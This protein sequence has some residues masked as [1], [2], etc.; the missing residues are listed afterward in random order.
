MSE[1]HAPASL[2]EL[3]PEILE[4]ILSYLPHQHLTSFGRTS[5]RANEFIRPN[6]QI[7][8][9][10]CYLHI[11]DHPKHVWDSLV[12][13]ARA[14]NRH[15][16]ATWDWHHELRRRLVAA[17]A[18]CKPNKER[19]LTD[20]QDVVDALLDIRDTA[21]YS[22]TTESDEPRSMNLRFLNKLLARAPNVDPIVHDYHRDIDSMSLPLDLMA[23]LDRPFTRSML[24][25][26][27]QVPEWASRLHVG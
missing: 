9:K 20:I 18:L 13:T 4:L 10:A 19:L 22:L 5:H 8:W 7:L 15:R 23:D 21:S 11:F 3:A 25:R 12:P 6:N 1:L 16:E 17:N 24:G 14:S 2:V 27:V 26:K